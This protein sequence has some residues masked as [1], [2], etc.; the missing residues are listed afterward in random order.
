M[1]NKNVYAIYITFYN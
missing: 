1:A